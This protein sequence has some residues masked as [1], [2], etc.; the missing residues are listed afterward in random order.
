VVTN[1]FSSILLWFDFLLDQQVFTSFEINCFLVSSTSFSTFNDDDDED[2]D[3]IIIYCGFNYKVVFFPWGKH[4]CKCMPLV[5]A[6]S[7]TCVDVFREIYYVLFRKCVSLWRMICPVSLA[8][9][10]G[11]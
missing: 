5:V 6:S 2:S 8:V 10:F 7:D 1:L 9:D 4:F 3:I 11:G